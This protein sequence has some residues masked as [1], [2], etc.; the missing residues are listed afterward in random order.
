MTAVV[1]AGG[2]R[3][4]VAASDPTAPNKAFVAIAGRTL[5]ERTID[6]LRASPHVA[7]IVAV[8]PAGAAGRAELSGAGAVRPSGPRMRDS[9]RS[10]VDG[11]P[12]GEQVLVAASDL[13]ILSQE[14]VDE[15]VERAL[16]LDADLV[17]ACVERAA[18]SSHP[19]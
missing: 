8:A 9:L 16:A 4:A 1:L 11:L 17:Y 13:P 19:R 5:V 12:P 3:D 14:A 10:G 2:K 6:A 18:C 7:E 15:F